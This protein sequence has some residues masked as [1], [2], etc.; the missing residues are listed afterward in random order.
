MT[1]RRRT[2]GGGGNEQASTAA[3]GAID[4]G[5]AEGAKGDVTLCLPKDVSGAFTKTI[6][7]FNEEGTGVTAKLLELPESADQQRNQLVQRSEARSGEC[8]VMGIDIIWTAEFASQG[9]VKDLTPGGRA[10][11]GRVHP[12]DARDGA[13]TTTSTGRCRTTPTP[14]CSTTAPTRCPRRRRRGRTS[15]SSPPRTTASPTRARPTRA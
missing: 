9:W 3:G 2:S 11:Q 5:A 12:L 15:T 10:A 14:R 8:D 7:A 4:A 6:A 13:T 1:T